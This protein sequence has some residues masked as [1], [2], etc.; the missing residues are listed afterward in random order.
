MFVL[1]KNESNFYPQ[2]LR[3][4]LYAIAGLFLNLE[5]SLYV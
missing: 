1:S 4:P 3:M 2:H 5:N